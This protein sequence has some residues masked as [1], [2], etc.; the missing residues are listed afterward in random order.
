[1][2][3]VTE[4]ISGRRGLHPDIAT[5]PNL[6]GPLNFVSLNSQCS[7]I[8]VAARALGMT[9]ADTKAMFVGEVYRELGFFDLYKTAK[10]RLLR[11]YA[12][13]GID[14]TEEFAGWEKQGNSFYVCHHP[15]LIVLIDGLRRA[16]LGR[17]LDAAAF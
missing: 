1:L 10:K 4:A 2:N 13:H 14:L 11:Q 17:Y 5:L 15:K 8:M 9:A 3:R 6:R 16:L 12:S 7:L